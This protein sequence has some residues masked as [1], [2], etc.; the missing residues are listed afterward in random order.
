MA[1]PGVEQRGDDRI[2]SVWRLVH[3]L[4]RDQSGQALVEAA[5]V[6]PI[7]VGL[8]LG[9]SEFSEAFT[10]SRRLEAAAA[11]SADLVG[12][13]Q[14]VTTAELTQIKP[15]LDEMIRPFPTGTFGVVITSAVTDNADNTTVAWSHADGSGAAARAPG[16]A[17]SLPAGLT[18]TSKSVIFSEVR[19]TFQSTLA[20]LILGGVPLTAEA[21]VRPRLTDKVTKTD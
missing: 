4:T 5:L 1:R 3:I 8:F 19:Y 15:L 6:L 7:M 18:E 2:G 11:T 9:V 14:T 13:L 16:S 20:T 21:Y 12:R 10:V 17:V